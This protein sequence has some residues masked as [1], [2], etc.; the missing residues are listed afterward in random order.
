M[1]SGQTKVGNF[2]V[3]L[4]A[5]ATPTTLISSFSSPIQVRFAYNT[6]DIV[7]LDEFGL[8]IFKWDGASWSSLDSCVVDSSANIVTC[9]TSSFSL[10][11]L[12]GEPPIPTS[13][14][15][16][17]LSVSPAP[18]ITG[19]SSPTPIATATPTT[20]APTI[21]N[22]PPSPTSAPSQSN[23]TSTT[24]NSDS[25]SCNNSSPSHEPDLFQIDTFAKTATLHFVPAGNPVNQY[26]V[27]YGTKQDDH[28]Y[29]AIF[30]NSDTT[31]VIAYSIYSLHPNTKYYFKVRGQN[32][33]VAGSWS[34]QM[35]ATTR[36]SYQ[37]SSKVYYKNMLV[38]VY[39]QYIKA[40]IKTLFDKVSAPNPTNKL[41]PVV[42]KQRVS[43][44]VQNSPSPK[45]APHQNFVDKVWSFIQSVSK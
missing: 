34:N 37:T 45:V 2:L 10:F 26:F 32:G 38:A 15:S 27:S 19:V 6:S 35:I 20:Q 17:T 11:G 3:Q 40:P 8:A 13:T 42:P 18:T 5:I 43:A 23:S 41:Q 29:A 4:Q 16:P 39:E 44:P 7:G 14:P 22:S 36:M 1:P 28:E 9:L 33:C 24:S 31:G 12:F 21:T 25:S 30:E